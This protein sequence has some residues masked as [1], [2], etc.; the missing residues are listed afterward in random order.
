M[1]Y[2]SFIIQYIFLII[3]L[4]LTIFYLSIKLLYPFWNL[5]PVLHPYD[6][7]RHIYLSLGAEPFIILSKNLLISYKFIDLININT[8]NYSKITD[9]QK[10][11]VISLLRRKYIYS[12]DILFDIDTFFLDN[13][14][15]IGHNQP[16]F[17][18]IAKGGCCFSYP[19]IF[20]I[21]HLNISKKA[22]FI[23]LFTVD[24]VQPQILFQTH[25]YNQRLTNSLNGGNISFFK[26]EVIGYLGISPFLQTYTYLYPILQKRFYLLKNKLLPID[27]QLIIIDKKGNN[28]NYIIDF[29]KLNIINTIT[30]DLSSILNLIKINYLFVFIMIQK[31]QILAIY[32]FRDTKLLYEQ[33]S[34]V[35]N[36]SKCIELLNSYNNINHPN[37]DLFYNGFIEALRLLSTKINLDFRLIQIPD[38]SLGNSII[39]NKWNN[40]NTYILKT[41]LAYY[42]FNFCWK[43]NKDN[44]LIIV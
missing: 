37:H 20:T 11:E 5:Q 43:C 1:L 24:T 28:F 3:I 10:K 6:L 9:S 14:I 19:I 35:D 40:K 39:L 44:I 26:K 18:S 30:I 17:V 25:E 21:P 12:S 34:S 22:Y 27:I 29:F 36:N 31:E 13:L 42:F 32:F 33:Y 4:F 7:F 8:F 38:I 16:S 41:F 15:N 23:D 2:Y